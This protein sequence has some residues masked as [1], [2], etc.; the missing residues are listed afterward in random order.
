MEFMKN[1]ENGQEFRK[2]GKL[3]ILAYEKVLE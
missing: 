1:I 3:Y 2:Y